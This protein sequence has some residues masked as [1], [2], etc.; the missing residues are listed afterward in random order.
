MPV[1]NGKFWEIWPGLITH[2]ATVLQFLFV[3][4]QSGVAEN[5][6]NCGEAEEVF[7]ALAGEVL[8]ADSGAWNQGAEAAPTRGRRRES[9]SSG[10]SAHAERPRGGLV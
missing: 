7:P 5:A 8:G 1:I 2:F 6:T 10:I 4:V 9:C 3:S